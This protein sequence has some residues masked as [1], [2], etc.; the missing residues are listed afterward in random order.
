[1]ENGKFACLEAQESFLFQEAQK[2]SGA[3]LA[4]YLM[5]TRVLSKDKAA[6]V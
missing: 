4:S 1:L 2:G 3:K 5:D 6:G